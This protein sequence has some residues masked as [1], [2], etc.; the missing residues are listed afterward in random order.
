MQMNSNQYMNS[1]KAVFAGGAVRSPRTAERTGAVATKATQN[2]SPVKVKT[3]SVIV[4][5]GSLKISQ[6]PR[7]V[8]AKC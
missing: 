6:T 4:R 7:K 3:Y 1:G 2:A 8:T 5:D